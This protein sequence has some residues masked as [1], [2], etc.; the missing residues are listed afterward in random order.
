MSPEKVH[1]HDFFTVNIKICASRPELK[2]PVPERQA[3]GQGRSTQL[4]N[5]HP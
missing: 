2:S 5:H 4:Y 3:P 1:S